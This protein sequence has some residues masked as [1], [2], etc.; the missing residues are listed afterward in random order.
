MPRAKRHESATDTEEGGSSAVAKRPEAT[1]RG[2]REKDVGPDDRSR[3]SVP[4]VLTV[5]AYATTNWFQMPATRN[6]RA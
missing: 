6:H 3:T 1:I 4:G 2:R 5:A